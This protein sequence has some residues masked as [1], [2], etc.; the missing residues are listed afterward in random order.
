MNNNLMLEI[1]RVSFAMDEL[2]L[3][4]DTHPD[5]AEAIALFNDYG[6]KRKAL[7]E[8]YDQE[9]CPLG[10]YSTDRSATW[11]WGENSAWKGGMN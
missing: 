9:V 11:R 1:Q 6:V 5:N 8:R 2:R 10:G 3:Y 7:I 4:I